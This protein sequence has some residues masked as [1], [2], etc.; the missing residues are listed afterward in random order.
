MKQNISN[1]H[2]TKTAQQ[3]VQQWVERL[4]HHPTLPAIELKLERTE[5]FM[6]LLG[7]PHLHLPPI[8]HMAGTNGK[9]ST[10]A[11]LHAIINA[12]NMSAHRY[13]SPHLV[14]FNERFIVAD[15][16]ISD[17]DLLQTLNDI[18]PYL[19]SH[20]I[21]YFEATTAL[22]FQL[23]AQNDADFTLLEVGMGGRFD[24]TNIVQNPAIT[25][26]API[27]L[28]HT[29]F[30]GDS[31]AK[32]AFEKAG[33]IK[34]NV[35]CVVGVQPADAIRVIEARANELHAPLFRHGV[36]WQLDILPDK[37]MRYHSQTLHITTNAP[38][39]L[40]NH[41][42]QNAA[43]AIACVDVLM[44]NNHNFTPQ[45]IQTGITS[46]TWQGRL[47]RINLG[48]PNEIY[49]D[50]GHNAAGAEMLAAWLQERGL[51]ERGL[52]E[53]NM[54]RG[55]HLI[56]GLK[57]DKNAHDFITK[58]APFALGLHFVPISNVTCHAPQELVKMA[59]SLGFTATNNTNIMQAVNN[60]PA[61]EGILIC[62]SLYLVGEAL[63]LIK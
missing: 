55:L 53:Q 12:A 49:V 8:I 23:F 29:E 63:S 22:A 48:V 1:S 16:Q 57:S 41:Q 58:L 15:M 37:S 50:G 35:P 42:Y 3:Q 24:S 32:I 25:A 54:E 30:L 61:N 36:E 34:T 38:S 33:I 45:A 62:G 14:H 47:Q 4:Q 9:G 31:I 60:I 56:I 6:S 43:L 17:D 26:I 44:Q 51:K 10:L 39:L 46:A 27:S 13:T 40:G 59:N 5:Q 19:T 11:F 2:N 21:T 7:N 18:A 20:S 28:D 52:Q